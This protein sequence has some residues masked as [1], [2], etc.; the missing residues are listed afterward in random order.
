MTQENRAITIIGE[1]VPDLVRDPKEVL[2]N[3][4]VAARALASVI[5]GKKNPIIA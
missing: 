3:A 1:I 2:E 5:A 4:M